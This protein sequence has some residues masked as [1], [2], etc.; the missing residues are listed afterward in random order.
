[1]DDVSSGARE[2]AWSE[3]LCDGVVAVFALWTV[4]CHALVAAGGGLRA[5][6]GV[7]AAA[8]AAA[9]A[10]WLRARRRRRA[11]EPD[12]APAPE[13][14][15]A[16]RARP[17]QIAGFAAG[18]AVPAVALAFHS[19]LAAW[20]VLVPLLALAFVRFVLLEP[21]RWRPPL[22]SRGAEA[23]LWA[24]AIACALAA[25]VAHRPDLDDT[26]YVN[27]AV[28]AADDPTRAL[29]S[30]DTL[31]GVAGL[32]LHMPA[33]R[34][35]SWELWNGALSYLT[36]LPAIA[37]FHLVSAALAAVLVPLAYA[38]LVRPL[39]PRAWPWTVLSVVVV[40]LAT[41][42]THRWYGNFAFV[43][44]WQGKAVF[45]F[46][47]LPLVQAYAV[48]FALRPGAGIWLLLAGA[49]IAAVG[50]SS[51]AV[52]A[53]PAASLMAQ[54]C[55]LRPSRAGL[56]TLG[57]GALASAYPLLAGLSLRGEIR[58]RVAD[59]LETS[60]PGAE[61]ANALYTVL[62]GNQLAVFA[63]AATAVAWACCPRGLAQRF[64]ITVPLAACA[65]FLD[66]YT[67]DFVSANVTGP[68][69]WRSMWSLPVPLLMGLVLSAPVALLAGR[70]PWLGRALCAA[71]LALY[72]AFVPRTA[73]LSEENEGA[74]GVGMRI[75]FP[76]LKVPAE[77]YRWAQ[78]LTAAVP[79]G[80]TVL[81]PAAV[82]AWIPTFH[83]A[84][85]PLQPRRIYLQRQAANLGADD[86]R[87]RR[88]LTLFVD[89]R[90]ETPDPQ[91]EFREGLERFGVQG[92]LLR[93]SDLA[94]EARATLEAAGFERRLAS[95]DYE[96]WVRDLP[97][98]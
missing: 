96:I 81:A 2:S 52:W 78:A 61:L 98:R 54:A 94:F 25:L 10:L 87:A 19:A 97:P 16:D 48:S 36:G 22:R 43:R 57:L 53:A 23:S 33:H 89:G 62:G 9:L 15:P 92:V 29:L 28:A 74:G 67:A 24:I 77:D 6:I 58:S 91:R 72:A 83:G 68:S 11:A 45:L 18:L 95:V 46:V 26:F 70:S 17:L 55:A 75:G 44:M 50:A 35:H 73:A 80:A 1:M 65:F 38:R 88:A 76:G 32:P 8:A 31:F 30:G 86:A 13:A 66:P 39:A 90:V 56:R 34:I 40:L 85:H 41:G 5:L 37:C 42:E 59:L 69:Y 51:S 71:L 84:A 14:A 7:F 79:P 3:R 60:E 64:A 82:S 21:L 49:Q 47:F 63:L 4:C 12:P 93:N 20:W 27:V